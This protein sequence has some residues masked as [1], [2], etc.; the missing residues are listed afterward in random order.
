MANELSIICNDQLSTI[1]DTDIDALIEK[2]LI[3]SKNN[4]DEI[5][6]LALECTSI[7]AS[8]ENRLD[9]IK[10]QGKFKRFIN[11]ITGK[12]Q[13]IRDA[14][15]ADNNNALF[16]A[17]EMI[18]HVMHE[19]NN[20][21]RLM[22]AINKRLNGIYEELLNDQNEI[23]EEVLH[24]RQ[25]IVTFYKE[26]Q[27]DFE[28]LN[29]FILERC[30]QCNRELPTWEVV[31]PSCGY[32]HPLKIDKFSDNTLDVIKKLSVE[33]Q[34][35]E[36][37]DDILWDAT[38]QKMNGVLKKID[39]I[40]KLGCIDYTK[41][42]SKDLDELVY[43]CKSAEFHIAIVG[44]MKAGKSFLMNAL[45]GQEVA[46]VQ[47]NPETAAL[48]KFR[49]AKG[50]YVN[51]KFH[52]KKE[53]QLLKKS[54]LDSEKT[55]D[56]SLGKMLR[57][58][59][60]IKEEKRWVGSKSVHFD[61]KDL[62]EL[63]KVVKEYTSSQS[64]MHLFVSEAEVGLD[65][66][67]FNMPKEVVFVDTPGL[68]DP[69]KYRSNITRKYIKNAN[70][71]LVAVPTAALTDEGYEVITT[72]LES[73]DLQKAYIV[74]TQKDIKGND[75]ICENIISLWVDYLVR[76]KKYKNIKSARS[77]IILT[78]AKMDLLLNKWGSLSDEQREDESGEY[79]STDDYSSLESFV[80]KTLNKRS[81]DLTKLPYDDIAMRET[82]CAT[83]IQLLRD[84]LNDRLIK[85]YREYLVGELEQLFKQCKESIIKVNQDTFEQNMSYIEL[86]KQGEEK[87][88][89]KLK[90]F[91]LEK[92][93]LKNENKVFKK[94]SEELILN[95][96]NV[97][98]SL[99]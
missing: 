88:Q 62:E 20:N 34:K 79:M 52:S 73:T 12:N 47:D 98:N 45:I 76:A 91:N 27:N 58:P 15:L 32:I 99:D 54:A 13:K 43:K 57:N 22:R 65:D 56:N 19:C 14:I 53:W 7:L 39:K 83:G 59:Q 60:I 86:A 17:Q 36:L 4:I 74:A 72:V 1:S 51:I 10:N 92:N 69:V 94:E 95:I 78:S 6:D 44:V 71:V 26:Y 49:S 41:E 90:S 81:Y 21:T 40:S 67:I 28:K 87:L 50:Y 96:T 23:S 42:I 33:V 46:S 38:A 82:Y 61:C 31:C 84:V 97:I 55:S 16:A 37:D 70:A 9:N 48:T 68:K 85:K 2:S 93:K 18:N 5:C 3:I 11:D 30:P 29:T 80:K 75:E 66:H 77:R 89:Q 63:R 8:S 64:T 25:L 35:D 24:T